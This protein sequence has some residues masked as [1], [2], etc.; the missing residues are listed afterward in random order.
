[1]I[2][3]VITPHARVRCF[4]IKRR[5]YSVGH[6]AIRLRQNVN[7]L[8]SDNEQ[9]SGNVSNAYIRTKDDIVILR[10]HCYSLVP[11]CSE[12]QILL[13]SYNYNVVSQARP[14]IFRQAP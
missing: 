14:G 9:A 1:M 7:P 2:Q 13:D 12:A 6:G 4:R 11:Q 8:G 3:T 5:R 10:R